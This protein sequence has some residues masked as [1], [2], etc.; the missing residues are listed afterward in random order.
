ME[1]PLIL[2][3]TKYQTKDYFSW[4]SLWENNVM[5][6]T[7][8]YTAIFFLLLSCGNQTTHS[9]GET[10]TSDDSV[11]RPTMNELAVEYCEYL[12]KTGIDTILL[13]YAQCTDIESFS[14]GI[15]YQLNGE[16]YHLKL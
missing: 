15:Y 2:I 9:F 6:V 12:R 14:H 5:R 16:V 7:L 4:Q 11:T 1:L 10:V 13:Q 8:Y 3:K